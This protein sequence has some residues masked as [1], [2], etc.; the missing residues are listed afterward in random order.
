MVPSDFVALL[1][2]PAKKN[3]RE[4][5]TYLYCSRNHWAIVVSL[6][7]RSENNATKEQEAIFFIYKL[8]FK[9]V[10][11]FCEE[12]LHT[13]RGGVDL[14]GSSHGRPS[15]RSCCSGRSQQPTLQGQKLHFSTKKSAFEHGGINRS[16]QLSGSFRDRLGIL[17]TVAQNLKA[18]SLSDFV[19]GEKKTCKVCANMR[20]LRF[21]LAALQVHAGRS[22]RCCHS[23]RCH[24]CSDCSVVGKLF[25]TRESSLGGN[26]FVWNISPGSHS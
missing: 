9:N 21:T 16:C 8:A 26:F 12:H 6:C 24:D 18:G 5:C 17:P 3:H 19:E 20:N 7:S 10:T 14:S 15:K 11:A 2:N 25:A 1:N 22:S 23:C 13:C 4:S